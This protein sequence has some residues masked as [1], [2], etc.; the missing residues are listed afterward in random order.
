MKSVT[1]TLLNVFLIGLIGNGLAAQAA[2]QQDLINELV[3]QVDFAKGRILQL[4]EAVPDSAY[5]WRPAEG[6]RSVSEAYLHM[7]FANYMTISVSGGQVPKESGFVMDFAKIKE[8]DTQTTEKAKI[9]QILDQ[10][11][12]ALKARISTINDSDLN[13]ETEVFGT[14]MTVRNFLI[15]MIAHCHEHL[16]QSIAYARMNGIVPPWSQ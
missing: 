8:W 13:R 10:S 7:A 9:K 5:E 4:E 11:F 15:S 6:V 12:E 1:L 16:G 2:S 14:K 3:G